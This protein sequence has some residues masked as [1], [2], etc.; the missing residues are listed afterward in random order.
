MGKIHTTK[1]C[2]YHQGVKY[3]VVVFFRSLWISFLKGVLV[4]AK[5]KASL[6]DSVD[7]GFTRRKPIQPK[8]SPFS[9]KMVD[10]VFTRRK[11][12]HPKTFQVGG[13]VEAVNLPHGNQDNQNFHI[14]LV[15]SHFPRSGGLD[16]V[17]TGRKPIHK[18]NPSWGQCC[19]RSQ[20][21]RRKSIQRRFSLSILLL[22]FDYFSL[23]K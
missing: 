15:L 10:I 19:C 7:S 8:F 11:P 13:S 17:L 6:K 22:S 16:R 5:R 20:F 12:I 1:F 23:S 4:R 2:F 9:Q 21:T 3:L 14:Q 18:K